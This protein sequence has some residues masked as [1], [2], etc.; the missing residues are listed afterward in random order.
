LSTS[1]VRLSRCIGTLL[2]E[3]D[4]VEQHVEVAVTSAAETV[5][6][7][8][9][10]R[11]LDGRHASECC[12]LWHTE[13][14]TGQAKLGAQPGRDDRLYARD[15]QQWKEVLADAGLDVGAQLALVIHEQRDLLC[16][17]AHRLFA[18]PIQLTGARCGVRTRGLDASSSTK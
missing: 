4:E 10:T 6:H 13:A 12:D 5:L 7:P 3:G 15:L 17:L 1:H 11:S 18:D 16:N 9:C 8:G 2:G 14:R